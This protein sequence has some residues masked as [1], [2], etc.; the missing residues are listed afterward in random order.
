MT[1]SPPPIILFIY[2]FLG[3]VLFFSLFFRLHTLTALSSSSLIL[4]Y[5]IYEAERKSRGLI[6]KFFFASQ[7]LLHVY[8]LSTFQR[9]QVFVFYIMF[10]F[11]PSLSER[12]R[13]KYVY[14]ISQKQKSSCPGQL[15][16]LHSHQHCL[17][18][19]VSLQPLQYLMLSLLSTEAILIGI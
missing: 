8:L 9:L 14:C 13:E 18:G 7:I 12:N 6:T 10:R 5:G 1:A 11:L 17:K 19:L 15:Y 2:L 3:F 4:F 16:N